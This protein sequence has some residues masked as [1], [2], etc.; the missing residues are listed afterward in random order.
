MG[1]N[2]VAAALF[3]IAYLWFSFSIDLDTWALEKTKLSQDL[4]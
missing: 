1:K 4:S 3:R 2:T